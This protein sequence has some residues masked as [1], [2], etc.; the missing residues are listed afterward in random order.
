[1]FL[2]TK[3]GLKDKALEF[4]I[5]IYKLPTFQNIY[6]LTFTIGQNLMMRA[7]FNSAH[8]MLQ[9]AADQYHFNLDK[10][11]KLYFEKKLDFQ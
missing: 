2:L 6:W 8:E 1:M 11:Y 3:L 9:K 4:A 10:T 7:Q 5:N